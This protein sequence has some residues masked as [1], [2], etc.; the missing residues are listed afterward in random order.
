SGTAPENDPV[1]SIIPPRTRRIRDRVVVNDPPTPGTSIHPVSPAYARLDSDIS[2]PAAVFAS[3]DDT[4]LR[5]SST[6]PAGSDGGPA[7]TSPIATSITGIESGSAWSPSWCT[8]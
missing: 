8:A 4:V 5:A 1:Y 7:S 3:P 6:A 2:A